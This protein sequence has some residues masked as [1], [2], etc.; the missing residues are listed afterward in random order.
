MAE[1]TLPSSLEIAQAAELRPIADVAEEV[2]LEPREIAPH[3]SYKAKI[4]LS[5][6][7]RL[8]DR[9]DGKLVCTTALTPTK[10]GEGTTTTSVS[11]TEAPLLVS[12]RVCWLPSAS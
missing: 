3:G 2:G 8:R 12:L 4:D 6:L 1:T 9:P 5:V 7:D 10:A 11:L